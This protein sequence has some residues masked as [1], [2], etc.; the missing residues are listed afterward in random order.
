MPADQVLLTRGADEAI[1][2]LVRVFCS[3]GQDAIIQTPPTFPMYAQS[4]YAQG[5]AIVEVP[6]TRPSFGVDVESIVAAENDH[7]GAKLVF[8]CSPNNPTGNLA[9]R[10][11]LIAVADALFGR[12]LVVIDELYLDYSGEESLALAIREH[13]NLVVLRSLS[14]EY[15]L[16]GERVGITIAD[17]RV[18]DLL[19]RILAPYPIPRSVIRAALQVLTSEGVALARANIARIVAERDRIAHALPM[20]PAVLK[21]YPSDANFLLVRV[22][23]ADGLA[24][25]LEHAGI[26]IRNRS[27]L[28]SAEGS[29]RISI[30]TPA[31]N[32]ALLAAVGRFG[33]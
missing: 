27:T 6:L 28:P 3:E 11:D 7:P 32:D 16:A 31:E 20:L 14:K 24:V 12:A 22:T 19:R 15:S 2:L 21:V 33:A 1:D 5:A 23:D 4:A 29:V 13:P 26:K 30:G 8:L 25:A 17:P 9:R 18:I 10:S